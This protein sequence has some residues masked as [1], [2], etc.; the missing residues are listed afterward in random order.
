MAGG[1][2]TCADAE[3]DNEGNIWIWIQLL[4]QIQGF[5]RMIH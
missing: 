3:L 1:R 2:G 4:L 5:G